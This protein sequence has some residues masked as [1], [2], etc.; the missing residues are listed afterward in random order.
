MSIW[1][2]LDDLPLGWK[3]GVPSGW[4]CPAW[5][6]GASWTPFGKIVAKRRG[7]GLQWMMERSFDLSNIITFRMPI[8]AGSS[9]RKPPYWNV[10]TPSMVRAE[11][12]PTHLLQPSTGMCETARLPLG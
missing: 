6:I 8:E 4:G 10:C 1:R 7:T 5:K 9:E 2:N 11:F 12:P 3:D